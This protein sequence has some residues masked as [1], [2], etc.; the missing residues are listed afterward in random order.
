MIITPDV[1]SSWYPSL[2]SGCVSKMVLAQ[3]YDKGVFLRYDK[4]KVSEFRSKFRMMA[5]LVQFNK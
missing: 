5:F 3:P 4:G 1:Y 2:M